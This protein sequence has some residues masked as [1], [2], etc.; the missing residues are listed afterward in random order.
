MVTY[1]SIFLAG[2]FTDVVRLLCLPFLQPSESFGFIQQWY[3]NSLKISIVKLSRAIAIN[4]SSGT[5]S[6]YLGPGVQQISFPVWKLQLS[7]ILSSSIYV[8]GQLRHFFS[9]NL[10]WFSFLSLYVSSEVNGKQI[11]L[12]N[13]STINSEL[14]TKK[15]HFFGVSP[16]LEIFPLKILNILFW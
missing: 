7:R 8:F 2:W 12:F 15:Y 4:S 14:V 16:L 6:L 1:F 9:S 3:L 11:L 10:F 5:V 13:L